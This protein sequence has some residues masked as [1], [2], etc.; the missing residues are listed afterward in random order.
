MR[1]PIENTAKRA[2]ALAKRFEAAGRCS[3]GVHQ[4]DG[5]MNLNP[6][7]TGDVGLYRCCY[8]LSLLS[9]N[10]M[11]T[12]RNARGVD[13][14]A[15]SGVAWTTMFSKSVADKLQYYVYRLI[16]PSNGESI[17][18][19]KGRADRVF[20]HV[21]GELLQHTEKMRK[22]TISNSSDRPSNRSLI[23][24]LHADVGHST[25]RAGAC[26]RAHSEVPR[27]GSKIRDDIGHHVWIRQYH[28]GGHGAH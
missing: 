28:N 14:I 2:A 10:V 5:R 7:I 27:A 24:S 21:K 20:E 22:N 1:G 17:Y 16:D 9:W 23:Y 6:Q 12:A 18:I 8:K 11:H 3:V 19:G 15:Y 4:R 13:I 25:L 26:V